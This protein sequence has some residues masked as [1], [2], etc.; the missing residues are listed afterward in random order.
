M[1]QVA[2]AQVVDQVN[3]TE[4]AQ[5]AEAAFAAVDDDGKKPA[6]EVK[7]EPP[8]KSETKTQ[9]DPKVA[10]EAAAKAAADAEWDGVPVKVR[11]TLEAISGKVG[12]IDELAH[13]VK[14]QDGRVGAALAGVKA[15]QTTLEAANAASRVSGASAPTQ[16]QV[17]EAMRSTAKWDALMADMGP[18]WKEAFEEKL[19][20]QAA[21]LSKTAPVVDTAGIKK[22]L[23][24][25]FTKSV[26]EIS[27][28]STQKARQLA[29]LDIKYPTW[30]QDINQPEFGPWLKTQAPEIQALMASNSAAEA[31][32]VLD[33]YAEHRKAVAEAT[34]RAEKNKRRLDSVVAP[35]SAATAGPQAISDREAAERAF[36]AVDN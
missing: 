11:Q 25:G 35:K 5:A 10:E 31:L 28:A 16:A 15:L 12:S 33:A 34:A 7:T 36:A 29:Q 4:A 19:A 32:K 6:P 20:A 18:D 9:A 8:A 3:E 14:S 13:I 24:E 1:N 17:K 26:Q 23:E 27:E 2:E 21:A 30:E 22:E